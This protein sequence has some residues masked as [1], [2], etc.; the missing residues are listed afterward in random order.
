VELR[1]IRQEYVSRKAM[2]E[3]EKSKIDE[4]SKIGELAMDKEEAAARFRAE[5]LEAGDLFKQE[6][7]LRLIGQ[8]M[9]SPSKMN[10]NRYQVRFEVTNLSRHPTEVEIEG[11]IVGYTENENK[12]YELKK[13]RQALPLRRSEVE[14]VAVWTDNVGS[15][16]GALKKFDPKKSTAVIY[17]GYIVRAYFNGKVVA[18]AASDGRL[19][20]IAAGENT[21]AIP[22]I[23]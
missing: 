15:F 7:N 17:R 8:R 14:S 19:A 13:I 5:A 10:D 16:A 20:R 9:S 3:R 22:A 11:I 18:H 2:L 1:N 4:K 6:P 23:K 21:E 12:L